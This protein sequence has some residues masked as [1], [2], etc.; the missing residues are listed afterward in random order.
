VRTLLI[1]NYDSYTY[2]LFQLLSQVNGVEPVVV[3]N[4][5][6]GPRWADYARAAGAFDN[7]VLSPGPGSPEVA[8][9]FGV[10]ADA[11]RE[12]RGPLLG[13]CLGHQ[14]LGLRHGGSVVHAPQVM[15]GRLSRIHHDDAGLF[16]GVPTAAEAVRYHSLIV[17]EES[18]AA[19]GALRPTAYSDDGIVMGLE[20]RSLPH[21]GVQF[22]PE[23]VGTLFG[24]RLL[25]NFRD[26]TLEVN[27]DAPP[28]GSGAPSRHVFPGVGKEC[29][30][31]AAAE[32]A[33][34]GAPPAAPRSFDV[35]AS[36]VG[37]RV[38]HAAVED[39][40]GAL[41][42]RE[43]TSFW[44]DSSN[45]NQGNAG[46]GNPHGARWSYMGAPDGPEAFTYTYRGPGHGELT[47][48]GDGTTQHLTCDVF[49]FMA[50]RTDDVTLE[51]VYAPGGAADVELAEDVLE[52][53][54]PF[55]GGLVGYIGYEARHDVDILRSGR[56]Q[57]AREEAYLNDPHVPDAF[58][59]FADRLLAYDHQTERLAVLHLVPAEDAAARAAAS[60]WVVATEAR[61]T[62]LIAAQE[63]L[64]DAEDLGALHNISF[65]PK[66]KREA[67]M[68]K[69]DRCH[70]HIYDGESYEL[71]LTTQLTAELSAQAQPSAAQS[72]NFYRKLR[73]KNPAPYGAY[74][75]HDPVGVLRGLCSGDGE[76]AD[77]LAICCSSPERFLRARNGVVESK[78]IKGTVRR[79]RADAEED[80]RLAR[81]LEACPKNR[82]ENLM[83]VDLVRNDLGR[84]CD[85]GSVDVP[86]LM[87]VESYETVH[88]LVSTV[89]GRLREESSITDAVKACFP[90]GSMTGAP[91]VRTLD[92]IHELEDGVP[93]GVYSGTLGFVSVSGSS[94]L[95]IVI[96]TAVITPEKV[97]LGA[98]GAVTA[99][100]DRADEFE[101]MLLKAESVMNAVGASVIRDEEVEADADD[102]DDEKSMRFDLFQA[103]S[104][105]TS[106]A[107]SNY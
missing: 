56:T 44:L 54:I 40:F 49:E 8:E 72:L 77:A 70:Q 50:S 99:L 63:D 47:M 76:D 71:C 52:S 4:D 103:A 106:S 67:Y 69:I 90:G 48:R 97:T 93:R 29:E 15:H 82:A 6:L 58:F 21:Y 16:R 98:G 66:A 102:D 74:L 100:S 86:R 89:T 17:D 23:S 57:A 19:D 83:I 60:A 105:S 53:A 22:H 3:P 37:E 36:Y 65:S 79:N 51:S 43:A 61:V 7:V 55:V 39:I 20:H 64:G 84:V 92:L 81:E 41:Y 30:R 96:R 62:E 95:N 5:A 28:Y 68:E 25:E 91:K 101:E 18:L 14:G 88:Q 45:L 73:H 2:N 75:F 13:V 94:D 26:I 42:G 32:A 9:D 107:F 87:K 27:G 80:A 31:E 38:P 11:L 12:Y 59:L 78:P 104:N 24:R 85:V 33:A 46:S 10:C 34:G 35:V 1:D